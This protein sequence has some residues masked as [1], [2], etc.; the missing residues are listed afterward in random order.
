MNREQFYQSFTEFLREQRPG[1]DF[2][3]LT[4][5][6]HL[7]DM[8]YLDSFMLVQVIVFLENISK[9]EIKLTADAIPT[10]FTF[11]TIYDTYLAPYAGAPR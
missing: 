4:P 8:A 3:A 10:F 1:H 6:T 2:V 5:T 11:E 7:L 9:R